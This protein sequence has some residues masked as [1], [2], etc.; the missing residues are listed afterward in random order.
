[1]DKVTTALQCARGIRQIER[2]MI[3]FPDTEIPFALKLLRAL[4]T[5]DSVLMSPRRALGRACALSVTVA[6]IVAVLHLM[7]PAPFVSLPVALLLIASLPVAVWL[8]RKREVRRRELPTAVAALDDLLTQNSRYAA[9][10]SRL[11]KFDF[12]P[13]LFERLAPFVP[14]LKMKGGA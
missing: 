12:E 5:V 9:I 3:F 7:T 8:L 10:L 14:Q 1:M 11:R 4:N 2:L 13:F 6:A